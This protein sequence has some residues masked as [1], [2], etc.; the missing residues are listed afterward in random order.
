MICG[1]PQPIF[2]NPYFIGLKKAKP[3]PDGYSVYLQWAQALPSSAANE[4]G[5]NVYFSS[6]KNHVLL[7]GP[8]YF[9]RYS[10]LII[11]RFNPGDI[12]FFLIRAVEYTSTIQNP[13]NF[14]A[15]PQAVN[16]FIYPETFLTL[17][18]D[19]DTLT[20]PLV[21]IS[22]FPSYGVL[23]V[24]YELIRYAN[25]DYI[26][27]TITATVDGRGYY[28][29]T[30]TVH[31]VDGYDGYDTLDPTVRHY[32]GWEDE[33]LIYTQAQPRFEQPEF[34]F[35]ESDGYRTRDK[36]LLNTDLSASDDYMEG[37]PAY[38]HSG[39]HRTSLTD[40]FSG[41]CL[42]SYHG[43]ESGCGA[44]KFRNGINLS[45]R[46]SQRLEEM[47]NV[48]GEPVVLLRRK[49]TGI[50]CNCYRL[51]QEQADGR[52]SNC[53]GVGF[54]GGYDQYYNNRRADSR[55]LMRFPPT[56]DD[57][58]IKPHGL[59][60]SF[61]PNNAWSLAIPFFKDRDVLIRFNQDNSEE[62]RYEVINVTR[63]KLMFSLSGA[64]SMTIYRLDR[65]DPVYQW[66]SIRDTS[67]YKG[68]LNTTMGTL[69]DHGP[70][71]HTVVINEGITTLS[72]I[73]STTSTVMSH[74]H[75]I[76]SGACQEILGHTHT[77]IL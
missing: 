4:I 12:I 60:Q 73:N 3:Y 5:Y 40:Y 39:Y 13:L 9:T 16:A 45:D 77:I 36:D 75:P 49:W 22:E 67:L 21:D 72:Q 55:I 1:T 74:N 54:V 43:G 11:K 70:H 19:A 31:T 52:C 10:E 2:P 69:R 30:A 76:I 46:S 48:S 62:F 34:P 23:N 42:G 35:T 65:T 6:N 47:L 15:S 8:K 20:I 32:T 27:N 50:T 37:F 63:N 64:Q 59:Q 57:L 38:D 24:G 7:E 68:T 66:R 26:T 17:N 28:N 56:Q 41:T 14:V 53:F 44:N 71:F 25:V 51:N 29:T 61:I 18:I 33:N 58:T